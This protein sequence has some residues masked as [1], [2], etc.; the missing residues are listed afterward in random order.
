MNRNWD[1]FMEL[2]YQIFAAFIAV[3]VFLA[4][5]FHVEQLATWKLF[6]LFIY[7]SFLTLWMK[8]IIITGAGVLRIFF[9]LTTLFLSL[10]APQIVLWQCN[11]CYTSI[12]TITIQYLLP[13]VVAYWLIASEI[14]RINLRV[15]FQD[16]F[17]FYEQ[18][19]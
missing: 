10:L 13:G 17:A 12:E 6:M 9:H 11:N 7:L 14:N 16:A 19:F 1:T 2:D 4:L 8:I 3:W 15:I 5:Q 18:E